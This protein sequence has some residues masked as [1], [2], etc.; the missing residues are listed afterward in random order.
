MEAAVLKIAII[1]NSGAWGGLEINLVKLA[2][3]LQQRGNEVHFYTN[4]NAAPWKHATTAGIPVFPYD[5]YKKLLDIKTIRNLSAALH[6]HKYPL[7]LI[8]RSKDIGTAVFAKWWSAVPTRLVFLQQMN[9]GVHKRDPYH[10]VIFNQLHRWLAPLELH[11]EEAL[12]YTRIHP[13]KIE[14]LP[15]CI[16]VS[17]FYQVANRRVEAR[18]RFGLPAD[19]FI[20]GIIGRPDPGKGHTY[21]LEALYALRQKSLPVVG[22]ILGL[23]GHDDRPYVQEMLALIQKLG[24]QDAII[25]HP[26]TDSVALGY[27]ALDVFV[28]ASVDEAFGMVTVE[29]MASK[30]PVV[31]TNRKGPYELLGKGEWGWIVPV[32]DSAA[33]AAQVEYLYHNPEAASEKAARAELYALHTFSHVRWCSALEQL[34]F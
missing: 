16:D 3:W 34:A 17:L 32:E 28:M 25:T 12:H 33:I 5:S 7:V 27:A 11:K 18:E 24:L 1:C 14:V 4:R 22:F 20:M 31:G 9:V 6:T 19:A 2:G 15:L 10:T 13:S 30:V 23:T 21:F 8:G 29:A 26:F